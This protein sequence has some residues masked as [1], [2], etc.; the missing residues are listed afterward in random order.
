M[1]PR[2]GYIGILAIL[3]IGISS[4]TG[5]VLADQDQDPDNANTLRPVIPKGLGDACVEDT[6]FMRRNHMELLK[7][8]RDET[9]LKGVRNKQYS[10]TECLSCHAVNGSDAAPVTV[11]DPKHFCRSCH[12]YAAV[13][14][15]CFQCHA[16][17]PEPG[18]LSA[19]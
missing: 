13:N 3:L 17:R 7:H 19:K 1:H 11:S 2:R 18:E 15:D 12:D 16:S 8:Q 5:V 4:L 10:L 14:I 6:D 9:T